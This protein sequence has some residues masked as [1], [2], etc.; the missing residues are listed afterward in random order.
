MELTYDVEKQ[1]QCK[2]FQSKPVLGSRLNRHHVNAV[3]H[4]QNL[5]KTQQS[6][7]SPKCSVFL[8]KNIPPCDLFMSNRA[9]LTWSTMFCLTT[10]DEPPVFVHTPAAPAHLTRKLS[11]FRIKRMVFCWVTV[12]RPLCSSGRGRDCWTSVHRLVPNSCHRC[13]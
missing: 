11:H 13:L 3:W 5:T 7:T 1:V 2:N 8:Q 10:N 4:G 12:Q 9:S 6:R